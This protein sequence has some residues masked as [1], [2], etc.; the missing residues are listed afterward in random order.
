MLPTLSMIFYYTTH[1]T[2]PNNFIK[3]LSIRR[4]RKQ[5]EFHSGPN[6]RCNGLFSVR[7]PSKILSESTGSV[8]LKMQHGTD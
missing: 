7:T 8:G 6:D 2:V 3:M 4:K 1:P 5:A